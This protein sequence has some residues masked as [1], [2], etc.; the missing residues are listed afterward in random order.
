M[1]FETLVKLIDNRVHLKFRDSRF[2]TAGA[3]AAWERDGYTVSV[4][5]RANG[6]F[7]LRFAI[8]GDGDELQNFDGTSI[9]DVDA[10]AEFC[11]HGVG[12][13]THEALLRNLT[14]TGSS[15]YELRR[16][17]ELCR[18]QWS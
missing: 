2:T 5:V 15:G 3:F 12:L 14:W 13:F 4:L 17:L 6:A 9:E 11:A 7:V 16:R 8:D 10:A 18:R 1:N